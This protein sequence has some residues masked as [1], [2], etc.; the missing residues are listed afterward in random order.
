MSASEKAR[1]AWVDTAKGLCIIM[2]V[3]V[4]AT[5]GVEVYAGIEGWMGKV[6]SYARPFRMPDF[7]LISGLFLGLVINRPW[8]RYIDRKVVHF[9][10]FYVLWLTIQFA[11]KAPGMAMEQGVGYALIAYAQAYFQPFGTLW[12][13]Y[14]LPLFFLTVR[15]TKTLPAWLVLA[16]AAALEILPVRSGWITFDEFCARFVF[17]YAGYLFAAQVFAIADWARA[18]AGKVF[19]FIAIWAPINGMLVFTPAPQALAIFLQPDIGHSGATGGIAE[20]P[21]VSL[22]LAMGG[23]FV[24]ISV[25]ALISQKNWSAWLTWLGAH[26]IVVY[27]AFFL[28][29]AVT[30][31][32]LLKTGIISD[33]G[34]IS[35]IT[36][37]AAVVGPVIFY[38][39]VKW[40]GYGAFL[41]ERP[42][43]AK[44][45]KP[46]AQ[47]EK[48]QPAE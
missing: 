18:N 45:D 30:R 4:H 31:T 24:V 11:F 35:L 27:L 40:S 6:V 34:T 7:F 19:A 36:T 3:M 47:S 46:S 10:Y 14:L 29:M 37:I 13:I 44:I 39:M 43:W 9:V 23:I 33:I 21:F 41:F 8:L 42:D 15:L 1:I 38:G 16:W 12:F 22:A 17:F 5:L 25:A 32:V 48:L 20:L 28:P 26:S 2:V